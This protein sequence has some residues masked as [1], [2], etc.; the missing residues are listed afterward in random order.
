MKV[1][2]HHCVL[3]ESQ[4]SLKIAIDGNTEGKETHHD[5]FP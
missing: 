5:I 2:Q 1:L 4:S 3:R